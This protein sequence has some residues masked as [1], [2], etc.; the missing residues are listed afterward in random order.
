[1]VTLR[2]EKQ[3]ER[4]IEFT[5]KK[6][7]IT[8]S[9]L[10]RRSITDFLNKQKNTN[11]WEVGKDLFGK[12]HSSNENLSKNAKFMVREKIEEKYK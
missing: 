1:M 7:D 10:I 6:L 11:A 2:L 12:Y 8:K 4:N 5:A 3:L 9:E